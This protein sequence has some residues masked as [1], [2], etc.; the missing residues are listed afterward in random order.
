MKLSQIQINAIQDG[1]KIL[2]T[3]VTLGADNSHDT[4]WTA[5]ILARLTRLPLSRASRALVDLQTKDYITKDYW[6]T[7]AGRDY[8]REAVKQPEINLSLQ[9]WK[10]EVLAGMTKEGLQT[11]ISNA[12]LPNTMADMRRPRTPE[13]LLAR[14]EAEHKARE[15]A[16]KELKLSLTEYNTLEQ[17][18]RIKRCP[19]VMRDEHIGV[20]HKGQSVCRDCRR[21]R[22]GKKH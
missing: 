6:V 7:S 8:Y 21:L 17:V 14:Y 12:V 13:E 19:G 9:S 4:V 3:M 1:M 5:T 2:S 16:A 18:G 15:S 11:R 10:E 22:R 20:F